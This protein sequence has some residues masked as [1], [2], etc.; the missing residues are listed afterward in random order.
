M[1]KSRAGNL[2]ARLSKGPLWGRASIFIIGTNKPGLK[3]QKEKPEPERLRQTMARTLT[4]AGVALS[5]S[6]F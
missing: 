1:S 2:P 5:N 3:A 4:H 6:V